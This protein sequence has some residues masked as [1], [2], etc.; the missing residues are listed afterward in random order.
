MQYDIIKN[1]PD[2]LA[3][4]YEAIPDN[5]KNMQEGQLEQFFQPTIIH[6]QVKNRLWG[7][8][9]EKTKDPN[10]KVTLQT[11]AHG[12]VNPSV[13]SDLINNQYILSWLMTP[14]ST[15]EQVSNAVLV[16]ATKRYQ[17]LVSMD[18][19]TIRKRKNEDG[20]DE[21]Y[22]TVDPKKAEILLRVIQNIENRVLGNTIQKNININSEVDGKQDHI[23]EGEMDINQ[24]NSKIA[25]LEGRLGKKYEEGIIEA[26]YI[27]RDERDIDKGDTGE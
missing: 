6:Y 18:I 3:E 19:T 22:E 24:I 17:D 25:E 13:L 23:L 9:G 5:I 26:T 21:Y 16:Q 14:L 1:V 27:Q 10:R 11:V 12:I 20:I 8:I 15:Y 2:S 4:K 7:E